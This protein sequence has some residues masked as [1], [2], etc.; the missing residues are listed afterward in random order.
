MK[1]ILSKIFVKTFLPVVSAVV[2]F[3]GIAY[4]VW[5]EPTAAPPNNNVEAPINVGPTT[6]TKEGGD[7][8]VNV[9]GNTKCLSNLAEAGPPIVLAAESWQG[10]TGDNACASVGKTCDKVISYNYIFVDAACSSATHCV[11]V[12]A[13]WYNQSL[14]GV[15]NGEDHDNIHDCSAFLG[16]HTTYLHAGILRCAGYFSAICKGFIAL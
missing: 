2:L 12:C 1:K 7:I 16:W 11:H 8:C 9:G 6:Q 3:A 5:T 14:P 10:W 13:A 4:A 15:V